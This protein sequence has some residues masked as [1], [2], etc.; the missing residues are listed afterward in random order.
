MQKIPKYAYIIALLSGF[1]VFALFG[2]IR[3]RSDLSESY[4]FAL[5]IG[6]CSLLSAAFAYI[7]PHALWRWGILVSSSFWI[8]LIL[9][10]FSYLFNDQ[11]EWST[12]IEA[13]LVTGI[14]CIGA[15][16]GRWISKR[17]RE[18]SKM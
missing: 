3:V 14:S 11:Y 15:I 2:L 7:W 16:L 13:V 9:V 10:F 4:A 18:S 8:F 12:V 1:L 6:F 17:I 5:A